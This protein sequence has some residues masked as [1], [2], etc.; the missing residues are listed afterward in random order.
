MNITPRN[1]AIFRDKGTGTLVHYYIEPEYEVHYNEVM[2]GTEQE[3]H[4]HER[5]EEILFIVDGEL[6]ARWREGEREERRIVRAGDLV[7]VGKVSHTFANTSNVAARF[8]VFRM[9]PDGIDKRE[10][11]QHDKVID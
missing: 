10:I 8:V 2:P 5:I 11:I 7:K 4:H 9:V 3:W 1:D 6:E